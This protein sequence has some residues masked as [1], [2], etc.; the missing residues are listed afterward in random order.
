MSA[1]ATATSSDSPQAATPAAPVGKLHRTAGISLKT[2]LSASVVVPVGV[3][4]SDSLTAEDMPRP[5]SEPP[6]PESTISEVVP[7]V[8][9][10]PA[11]VVDTSIVETPDAVADTPVAG[12]TASSQVPVGRLHR[13]SGISIK[14]TAVASVVSSEPEQVGEPLTLETLTGHW[15]AMLEAMRTDLPKLADM[16]GDKEL[17][18]DK[19]DHFLIVVS[20]SY[21]EAEIKPYLIRM[22]KYLRTRSHRPM[23]NCRVEVEYVEHESVAYSPRDKYDVMLAAN[24]NLETF[25]ILFPEVDY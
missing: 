15:Q 2:A 16:L 23:L 5:G 21:F 19:E 17:R 18:I 24:P 20:N 8:E 10:P 4:Q 11:P 6:A 22:L 13:T 3:P 9:E 14:P 25:R 7:N 12:E 1:N